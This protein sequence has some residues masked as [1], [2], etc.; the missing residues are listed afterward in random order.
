MNFELCME[1]AKASVVSK[2]L[3]NSAAYAK[4]TGGARRERT[5]SNGLEGGLPCLRAGIDNL[6]NTG[7][8]KEK[9]GAGKRQSPTEFSVALKLTCALPMKS[10]FEK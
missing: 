6:Q 2:Q 9:R 4:V 8:D 7:A 10:E 5:A 1:E 3:N